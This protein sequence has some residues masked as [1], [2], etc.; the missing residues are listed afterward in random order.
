MTLQKHAAAYSLIAFTTTD[1][2]GVSATLVQPDTKFVDLDDD[3]LTHLELVMAI[4][5]EFGVDIPDA[6]A[7]KIKT[8]ADVVAW[9]EAHEFDF[10][11]LTTRA[12]PLAVD[13]AKAAG[14]EHERDLAEQTANT[15]STAAPSLQELFDRVVTAL[16]LQG[17][18]A[19]NDG[20]CAYRGEDGSKCAVGHLISDEVYRS[21]EVALDPD[22]NRLEEKLVGHELVQ[23]AL[24]QS[25]GAKLDQRAVDML[26]WLQVAHDDSMHGGQASDRDERQWLRQFCDAAMTV[27]RIYGLNFNALNAARAERAAKGTV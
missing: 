7:E 10:D 12:E 24:A 11:S 18:P 17:R 2:L 5:D 23:A 6:D 21:Y 8:P 22:M 3:S 26:S 20:A 13:A 16:I 27:G 25:L 9:L 19:L 15:E 14:E 4:E 1:L